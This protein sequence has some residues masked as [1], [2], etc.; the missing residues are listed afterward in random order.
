MINDMI[1]GMENL[2]NVFIDKIQVYGRSN[3]YRITCKL[4]M[5]DHVDHPSWKRIEMSDMKIKLV[6]VSEV[7]RIQSLNTGGSSLFDYNVGTS[8]TKVYSST[9]FVEES[10]EGDYK[11]YSLIVHEILPFFPAD[12]SIYAAC[13]F[14]NLGF[15]NNPLFSK[16]YGPMVS[17][18]VF[19]NGEINALSSYFFYPDTNEEYGGPVHLHPEK[20]YMEGSKHS[21]APHRELILVSEDNYKI[22]YFQFQDTIGSTPTG[23]PGP[24]DQL[25]DVLQSATVPPPSQTLVAPTAVPTPSVPTGGIY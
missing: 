19:V 24:M 11:S 17:E 16:Y 4:K 7:S 23:V 6:Y 21:S 5:F 18:K 25:T 13:F 1:V 3:G 12:L 15:N 20:G 14:E 2:P 10:V 22:Q 9:S 8:R